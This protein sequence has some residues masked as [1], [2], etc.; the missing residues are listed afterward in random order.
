MMSPKA[1]GA[2]TAQPRVQRRA[3]RACEYC[4]KKRLKCTPEQRPCFNCQ[5]YNAD[6]VYTERKKRGQAAN[7]SN[8][9]R[10]GGRGEQQ[11]QENGQV[12]DQETRSVQMSDAGDSAVSDS[13]SG[14]KSG[15]EIEPAPN[16]VAAESP[17]PA[18]VLT[19][20]NAM[21][22][23]SHL[24]LDSL[25]T[26][27][28]SP[29]PTLLDPA[30]PPVMQAE[31]ASLLQGLDMEVPMDFWD[32]DAHVH[33]YYTSR[34]Q[35]PSPLSL[36]TTAPG[37]FSLFGDSNEST[38]CPR[39]PL[40]LFIGKDLR[41]NSFIGLH[42]AGSTLAV[43]LKDCLARSQGLGSLDH[44]RFLFDA[45]PHINQ[46]NVPGIGSSMLKELPEKQLAEFGIQ[47]IVEHVSVVMS[48]MKMDRPYFENVHPIYPI[49]DRPLFLENWQSL[50]T[51]DISELDHIAFSALSLVVAI[52]ILSDP[53]GRGLTDLEESVLKLYWQA[54]AF[55]D[56][57]VGTPYIQSVQILLLH[58][59]LQLQ[60]GRESFAWVICGLASRIAQSLGLHRRSP[61]RFNLTE[62][63]VSLRSHLWW[64]TF[65]L[66]AFLSAVEGRPTSLSHTM[67]DHDSL[68]L[69]IG[70][71]PS[72]SDGGII[73]S[74]FHWNLKLAVIR[75]QYCSVVQ[76]SETVRSRLEALVALDNTLVRWH[77]EV[78]L[79]IRPGQALLA[80][81]AVHRFI[82]L[83]HLEY[84]LTM[85]TIHWAM[86]LSTSKNPEI[87]SSHES[88]R[89]QASE[90]IC[91]SAARS[92]VDVLNS[93]ANEYEDAKLFS[94]T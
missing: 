58:V 72:G 36:D 53:C 46:S 41:A 78:P 21:S 48:K 5:L 66:D 89:I 34:L 73:V 59:I 87:R 83:L 86:V 60:M 23:S 40:G 13:V 4:R 3:G 2:Q 24:H 19:P 33:P 27:G 70:D 50:Y 25:G 9:S 67:S 47:G 37:I 10:D 32:L 42:S 20:S 39:I 15:A 57:V 22:E 29:Q 54:W 35:R 26:V 7:G 91:V 51:K 61:T 79:E 28:F 17:E 93:F 63:E 69:G 92:F 6:C 65:S 12:Q 75:H 30:G 8:R 16:R 49:V 88:I 84:F 44:I 62:Q 52:G 11:T 45:G 80:P 77:E 76:R 43:C 71:V 81:R 14:D 68:P 82:G 55:L 94:I 31:Y 18:P 1:L 64:V 90:N 38:T 56:E 74:V 85:C